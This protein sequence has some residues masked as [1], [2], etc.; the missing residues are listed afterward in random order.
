MKLKAYSVLPN[1][2]LSLGILFSSLF[3]VGFKC[4]TYVDFSQECEEITVKRVVDGDTFVDENNVKYRLMGVDTPELNSYKSISAEPYAKKAT[5]YTKEKILNQK[6][7]VAYDEDKKD[8]FNRKLVYAFLADG[9]MLNELLLVK[10]YA[11]VYLKQVY[12]KKSEFVRLNALAQ[13]AKIG[14]WTIEGKSDR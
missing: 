14:V 4:P 7:V 3:I 6:I 1:L 9:K 11:K 10:G 12:L 8:R 2:L 5:I 13:K